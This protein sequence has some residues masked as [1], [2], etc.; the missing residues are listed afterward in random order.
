MYSIVNFFKVLK[1]LISSFFSILFS[2]PLYE[3][4][5]KYDQTDCYHMI[6]SAICISK[7]IFTSPIFSLTTWNFYR[8]SLDI[9]N[10]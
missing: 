3:P 2:W 6:A 1:C 8:L 9:D 4:I 10:L 5:P 7:R